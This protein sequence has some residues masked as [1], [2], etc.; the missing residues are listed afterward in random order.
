MAVPV[1]AASPDNRSSR[2]GAHTVSATIPDT[3]AIATS[4]T[5]I[6]P[7]TRVRAARTSASGRELLPAATQPDTARYSAIR[8]AMNANSPAYSV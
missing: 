1:P 3:A 7:T 2:Y 4:R 5:P 6:A 8:Q